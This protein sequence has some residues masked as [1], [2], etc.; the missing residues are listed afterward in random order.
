MCQKIEFHSGRK[1]SFKL[2]YNVHRYRSEMFMIDSPC[3][4]MA[5]ALEYKEKAGY[6]QQAFG[7]VF[8]CLF[9]LNTQSRSMMLCQYDHRPYS[10]VPLC[11]LGGSWLFLEHFQ[12]RES[13][14]HRKYAKCSV[15]IHVWDGWW[16]SRRS[17]HFRT[18]THTS[19]HTPA[20]Q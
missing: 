2:I 10:M 11:D 9:F 6:F 7:V 19:M 3:L 4:E 12:R 16:I 18:H 1:Y 8:V 17:P 13:A 15:S 14:Q 5:A 20:V